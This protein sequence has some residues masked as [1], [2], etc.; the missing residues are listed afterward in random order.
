MPDMSFHLKS[1]LFPAFTFL[2]FALPAFSQTTAVEG[3]VKD[4]NGKLLQ[5]AVV[6][7]E[8]TDIKGHYTV[9]SD[10]KGHYGHYGLPMGTFNITVEV[11]GKVRDTMNGVRTKP[12]DPLTQNFDLKQTAQQ[13]QALSKAAETGTL[14]KEQERGMTKEQKD[15]FDKASKAREQQLQKNKALNDTFTVGKTA[16]EAKQYDVA[17]EN[18]TKASEMDAKQGAVWSALADA[19][20]GKAQ[21]TPAEAAA[22]Y[23]KGFD[24]FKKALEITPDDAGLYN[25]YALALAKDKKLDDAKANLAK[26]AQ[27]DPPGAGKYYYNLGAL[28]VNGG[29][30][31]VAEEEFKKATDADPKYA[32]AWF[33]LGMALSAKAGVDAKT[34]KVSPAPGT[35]E[36]L[37]KYLE[38]KPDGV[39]AQSAKEMIAALGGTVSTTFGEQR[40]KPAE[41]KKK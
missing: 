11:D 1:L 38:L 23:D 18:L 27:L 22:N 40:A 3:L 26:A 34:G 8:R 2:L 35:V 41:K 4:E 33:Q 6:T 39:N 14:T 30:N 37:Q 9:K 19:Y 24:A 20:I 25:N 31:A 16:L 13:Q 7:F 32:D 5:G 15:Q 17:I 10:K 12:G 28:L 36:A 21:A 29:Q